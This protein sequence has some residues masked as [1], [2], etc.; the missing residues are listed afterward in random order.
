MGKPKAPAPPD[1]QKVAGAQTAQNIGTAITQQQLN[2]VNQITPD[3]TLRYQ[4]SIDPSFI[5]SG[6]AHGKDPNRF[7]LGDDPQG[8]GFS[9]REAA[10]RFTWENNLED[11]YQTSTYTDP[12]TGKEYEIP[13][14]TAVQTL[15]KDQQKL[16]RI[17][18]G[19]QKNLAQL[20]RSQSRRLG[21]LLSGPLDTKGLP[22]AGDP[23]KVDRLRLNNIGS[24]PA[25]TGKIG[26]TGQV[27]RHIDRAGRVKDSFGKF[28]DV[29][30]KIDGAG[31]VK[32]GFGGFGSVTRGID[33]AGQIGQRIEDGGALTRSYGNDFSEDRNKVED[34]LMERMQPGL[35][36]DRKALE[37]RLASQGIRIGSEAYQSAMGD[38]G[39]QANDARLSAILGAGQEHSRLSGMEAQRAQFENSAQAQQFG[40]N[41]AQAQFSNSAQAQRFGQN[42]AQ[43]QFRNQAQQQRYDQSQGQAAFANNV[44]AQRFGQNAT[45]AQFQNQAQQQR[46]DQSQGLAEFGNS[47]QQQR[48]GQNATRA[49]FNNQAQQQ[50]FGQAMART[51]FQ[52][53]AKQQRYQNR[54]GAT[55]YN[56]QNATQEYNADMVRQ[57]AKTA[58]R[59]NALQEA[60]ALRNQPINEISALLSGSQ[61]QNPNFISPQT[62]Q[63]ANTD[64]AGITMASHN[65]ALQNYQTQM[66]GWNSLVGGL[67]GLGG[68]YLGTL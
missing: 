17:N 38:H 4:K 24:G 36:R 3:G 55:Q 19:T 56:N 51:S 11:A 54:V 64:V 5:R 26:R 44:Q 18:Q 33:D 61:V 42:A 45:Q 60:F 8:K 62:A 35:Q 15:S 9:S 68:A 10:E 58:T 2:N 53:D 63:L 29:T 1:P 6:S 43:A 31:R 22:E 50:R 20:G 40:Q 7:Y 12:N 66:G 57:D 59:N 47:A 41:A 21:G 65:A 30:R 28:G 37:T 27:D 25:I 13:Q 14:Y 34:A 46:Y 32:G 48:F 52:N 39:R 16:N 23:S 67:G 49:Q